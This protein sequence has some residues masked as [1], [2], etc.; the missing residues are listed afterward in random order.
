MKHALDTLHVKLGQVEPRHIQ[1]GLVILTLILFVLGA[2]APG[3]LG[4]LG[5]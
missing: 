5:G 3:G 1:L 2:G 4:D